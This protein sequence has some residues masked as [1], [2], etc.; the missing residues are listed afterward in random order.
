MEAAPAE[1]NSME[2]LLQENADLRL[3]VQARD[4]FISIAAHE[5]RNPMTPLAGQIQLLRRS[6]ELAG[7]VVPARIVQGI[8]RLDLIVRRY[9]RRT[10][11]LLDISRLTTGKFHLHIAMVD[12]AAVVN[13]VAADFIIFANTAGSVLS[14]ATGTNIVGL[15][16][17]TAVEE[18]VENLVSNAVKYGSGKPIHVA[19]TRQDGE[20]CLQVQD[21]GLG[22]SSRDQARVFER[23]ERLVTDQP[24]SGFG[25]GLW[26]VG[27]LV[28]AM[29]GAITIDSQPGTGSTFTVRLP[30]HTAGGSP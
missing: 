15:F 28:A 24:T 14:V 21:H 3:A 7:D 25:L 11:V 30:L 22:I 23:F 13:D 4:D 29:G 20:V 9:I 6:A 26:V 8:E 17:Q 16:D 5:L 27:Q 19:L 18:I 1:P 2:R 12:V 10:T